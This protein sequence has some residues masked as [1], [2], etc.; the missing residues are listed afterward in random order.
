MDSALSR[1]A[2]LDPAGLEL[3]ESCNDLGRPMEGDAPAKP[4]VGNLC[5]EGLGGVL[6]LDRTP[7]SGFEPNEDPDPSELAHPV[8]F[9][10]MEVGE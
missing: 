8:G 9:L 10:F 7:D 4:I 3:L 2:H 1:F 5:C 6:A